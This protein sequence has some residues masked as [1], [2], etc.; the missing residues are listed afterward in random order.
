MVRFGGLQGFVPSSQLCVL[1]GDISR[2][3]DLSCRVGRSLKLR[4]IELDRDNNRLI[5]SERAASRNNT[6]EN[7]L[8]SLAPGQVWDGRVTSLCAFGAFVD[9][10]GVEGFVHISEF[11]WGRVD[12]PSD[13]LKP[14]DEVQVYIV[15]V[16]PAQCRVSLSLKQLKPN[17]WTELEDRYQIGQVVTGKVTNVVNFGVFRSG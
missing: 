10:G 16:E 13:V 6:A 9:L 4:I 1:P 8:C 3:A 12:H 11:S 17:P 15:S 5:F 7:L 14:G 2:Q